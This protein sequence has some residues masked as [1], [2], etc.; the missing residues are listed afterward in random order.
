VHRGSYKEVAVI[1]SYTKRICTNCK[2]EELGSI[3]RIF[4]L[5]QG[6]KDSSAR[7]YKRLYHKGELTSWLYRLPLQVQLYPSYSPACKHCIQEMNDHAKSKKGQREDRGPT[8]PRP[9]SEAA[10]V[11]IRTFQAIPGFD[12]IQAWWFEQV[13]NST[14]QPGSTV[15][16]GE[17][18]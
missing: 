10:L 14:S 4:I 11:P 17:T 3:P 9:P 15:S 18:A 5:H 16:G 8:G 6:L 13:Y 12:R 2:H 1:A 7:V